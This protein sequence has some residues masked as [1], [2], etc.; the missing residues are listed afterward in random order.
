[1]YT[2]PQD[3]RLCQAYAESSVSSLCIDSIVLCISCSPTGVNSASIDAIKCSSVDLGDLPT[4]D[5]ARFL[6]MDADIW[7]WAASCL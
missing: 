6:S 1:M 2:K 4:S 5:F 7:C 3:K